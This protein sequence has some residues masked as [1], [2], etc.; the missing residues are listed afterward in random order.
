MRCCKV[1][2]TVMAKHISD[3][4]RRT[5]SIP[6]NQ[7]RKET[8]FRLGNW[9]DADDTNP[10]WEYFS[11]RHKATD[12]WG[13]AGTSTASHQLRPSPI[14]VLYEPA[15]GNSSPNRFL[16]VLLSWVYSRLP[17]KCRWPYDRLGRRP[18]QIPPPSRCDCAFA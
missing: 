10:K 13:T 11:L 18:F 2:Q 4:N 12:V 14:R 7:D 1:W 16:F 17:V 5:R 15:R 3:I 6:P 8:V 9:E